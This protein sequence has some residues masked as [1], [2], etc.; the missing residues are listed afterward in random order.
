MPRN[1]HRSVVAGLVLSG[2][3][4]RFVPHEVLP[5][6]GALGVTPA[7]LAAVLD[8]EPKPAAVLLTR[9]SYYGLA[10]DLAAAG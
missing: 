9:P 10:R 3:S 4:P 8:S 7:A 1:I 2:A 5:E 6:C